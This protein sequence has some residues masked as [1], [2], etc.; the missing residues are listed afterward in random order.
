MKPH[1][2]REQLVK[3]AAIDNGQNHMR[4]RRGLE[5]ASVSLSKNTVKRRI[6]DLSLNTKRPSG[7][8][9]EESGKVEL[10]TRWVDRH[11]KERAANGLRE[12]RG[13]HGPR[14]RISVLHTTDNNGN[15]RWNIQRQLPGKRRH[16]LGKLWQLKHWWR[17]CD[18]WLLDR[19]LLHE[20]SKSMVMSK[21]STVFCTVKTLLRNIC[22]RIFRQWCR[23]LLL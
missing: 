21:S 23:R 13:L 19:G 11:W 10:S 2:I 1:T 9:N 5:F 7:G 18:A 22:L 8:L 6:A 14:R 4:R 3:P 20:S 16:Q 15:W 17:S 12:V